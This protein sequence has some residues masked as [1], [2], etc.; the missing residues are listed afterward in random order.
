MCV[1]S[2]FYALPKG[3]FLGPPL[4]RNIYTCQVHIC[5]PSSMMMHV[6]PQENEWK[7]GPPPITAVDIL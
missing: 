2:T 5:H 3:L 6:F 1:L 7:N 4:R